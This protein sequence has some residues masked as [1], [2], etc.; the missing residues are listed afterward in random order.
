VVFWYILSGF[1]ILCQEKSGNP[2]PQNGFHFRS[3]QLFANPLVGYFT[4][5]RGY[6]LPFLCGTAVLLFSSIRKITLKLVQ[7]CGTAVLL[8]SSIRKITLKLV[9]ICGTA[10]L[11]FSSI[12]KITLN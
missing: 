2:G 11:L 4:A 12:R 3:L 6:H 9:Q 7:I 5:K 10:V 1:G 8:F